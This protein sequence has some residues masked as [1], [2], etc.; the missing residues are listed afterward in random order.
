MLLKLPEFENLPFLSNVIR[1][2][3]IDT[4][5]MIYDQS[6]LEGGP[7]RFKQILAAIRSNVRSFPQFQHLYSPSPLAKNGETWTLDETFDAEFHVRHIA[8]PKPGDWRQ[9]CIQIARL[10]AR[11][12]DQTRPLWEINVVEG[13]DN[14]TEDSK[15]YFA[16]VCKVHH[17][18]MKNDAD[19]GMLWSLHDG[20]E[21]PAKDS[22]VVDSS[23]TG[24]VSDLFHFGGTKLISP[25]S[26]SLQVAF[27]QGYKVSKNVFPMVRFFTSGLLGQRKVSYTRFNTNISNFRVWETCTIELEKLD[28]IKKAFP[29]AYYEHVTLS[30][31]G[32][33]LKT[34]LE[35]KEELG[36]A[37]LR[38]FV[39]DTN[40]DGENINFDAS[41]MNLATD[42]KEF[43]ERL[44]LYADDCIDRQKVKTLSIK[45]NKISPLQSLSYSNTLLHSIQSDSLG[46]PIA[47]T[48]LV[49]LPEY[50]KEVTLLGAPLRYFS[51][52]PE[53]TDGLG[54]IHT[55]TIIDGNLNLT[56]TSCREMMTEPDVYR[57]T[58]KQSAEKLYQI[59]KQRLGELDA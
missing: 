22:T 7:L 26:Q 16:L 52:V 37:N 20:Y 12:L 42:V 2:K 6:D 14:V 31:L 51:C 21:P 25:I 50:K 11:P 35:D 10:H 8:L 1:G 43:E 17:A 59:A 46:S 58:L 57:D 54:L 38:T 28:T 4:F 19:I 33:A 34:F 23:L 40:L 29:G 3:Q 24:M 49:F 36:S 39:L 44:A 15:G 45:A 32:D 18:L 30:I 5:V 53:I 48:A 13:L 55:A 41:V 47:N 56:F 9:F 27:N